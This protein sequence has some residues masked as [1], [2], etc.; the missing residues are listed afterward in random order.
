MN[1]EALFDAALQVPV[2]ELGEWL[3]KVCGGDRLLRAR[4]EALL[5]ADAAPGHVLDSEVARGELTG[6]VA[7]ERATELGALDEALATLSAVKPQHAMPVEPRS[8]G[9]LTGDEAAAALEVSPANADLMWQ[10]IRAWLRVE[11]GKM[12]ILAGGLDASRRFGMGEVR[13]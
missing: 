7:G 5:A 3:E 11:M 8:F 1:E 12:Q 10:Y 6:L 4:V 9:G 2:P 13:P